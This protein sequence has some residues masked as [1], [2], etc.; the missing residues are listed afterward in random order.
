MLH[1]HYGILAEGEGG[2]PGYDISP[3]LLA[4][5]GLL[6]D[7]DS[8]M[9][10][11]E[12]RPQTGITERVGL[13]DGFEPYDSTLHVI[14]TTNLT[15][16]VGIYDTPERKKMA[17]LIERDRNNLGYL[18]RGFTDGGS[19]RYRLADYALI[20][21]SLDWSGTEEWAQPNRIWLIDGSIT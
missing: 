10:W 21:D 7:G 6:T 3:S 1:V 8:F 17:E 12:G 2:Y 13:P 4:E 11:G 16:P 20:T 18:L 9:A 19:P 5:I 14:R 15:L